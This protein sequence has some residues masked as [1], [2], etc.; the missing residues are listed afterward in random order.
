MSVCKRVF[1]V[2]FDPGLDSMYPAMSWR[3]VSHATWWHD[4]LPQKTGGP[5][6]RRGR[7]R[8]IQFAQFLLTV[9]HQPRAGCIRLVLLILLVQVIRVKK[10]QLPYRH[11][12]LAPHSR[13]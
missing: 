9:A 1:S 4:W 2:G 13:M 8:C 11:D 12:W 3:S 10:A 7:I 6:L 5:S